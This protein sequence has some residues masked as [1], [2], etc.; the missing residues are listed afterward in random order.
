MVLLHTSVHAHTHA[1]VST[2]LEHVPVACMLV[3][4][5]NH[6]CCYL[7][8]GEG[9]WCSEVQGL[10]GLMA[11][12]GGEGKGRAAWVCL[13]GE[14]GA[15]DGVKGVVG[16]LLPMWWGKGLGEIG[17]VGLQAQRPPNG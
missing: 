11:G 16:V 7:C 1:G 9:P 14:P 6:A 12:G 10:Q 3:C 13:G 5:C 17:V 2:R 15:G 8:G 4:M